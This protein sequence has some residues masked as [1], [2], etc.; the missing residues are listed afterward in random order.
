MRTSTSGGPP[1]SDPSHPGYART[2]TGATGWMGPGSCCG[3]LCSMPRPGLVATLHSNAIYQRR[4]VVRRAQQS[5]ACVCVCVRIRFR[6]SVASHGYGRGLCL[7]ASR[8]GIIQMSPSLLDSGTD[9][10]LIAND[11]ALPDCAFLHSR[12]SDSTL[13]WDISTTCRPGSARHHRRRS[14]GPIAPPHRATYYPA[15][16]ASIRLEPNGE[17][18]ASIPR[19]VRRSFGAA[20]PSAAARR[21]CVRHRGVDV[22]VR[23]RIVKALA[24]K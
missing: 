11:L 8:L 10:R 22:D 3:N 13:A 23:R 2:Q 6:A 18:S 21:G 20:P 17:T 24:S 12:P 16:S 14:D 4:D 1:L 7:V 9:R 5:C 15:Q 19:A